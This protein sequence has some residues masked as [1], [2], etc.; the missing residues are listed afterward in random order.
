MADRNLRGKKKVTGSTGG[1][2]LMA[3]EIKMLIRTSFSIRNFALC[4]NT[5][6]LKELAST[7][8]PLVTIC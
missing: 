7:F 1:F 4:V 5:I 2:D 6:N 8:S 3:P